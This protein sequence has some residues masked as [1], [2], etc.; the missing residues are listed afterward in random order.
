MATGSRITL[1]SPDPSSVQHHTDTSNTNSEDSV[2]NHS[3]IVT[4]KPNSQDSRNA[5][6]HYGKVETVR[7]DD[8]L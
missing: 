8:E 6:I 1:V 3:D 5:H 7:I 4:F 2:F